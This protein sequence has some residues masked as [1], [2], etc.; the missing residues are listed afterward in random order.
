MYLQSSAVIQ[1]QDLQFKQANTA[2][3]EGTPHHN[4]F[5]ILQRQQEQGLLE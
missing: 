3:G 2:Q 5:Q 4:S 1:P